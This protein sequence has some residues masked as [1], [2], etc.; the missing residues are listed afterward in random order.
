VVSALARGAGSRPVRNSSSDRSVDA[1]WAER[2]GRSE[3]GANRRVGEVGGEGADL[4]ASEW[5]REFRHETGEAEGGFPAAE[6]EGGEEMV[7]DRQGAAGGRIEQGGGG[8]GMKL[9]GPAGEEALE[10]AVVAVPLG[11]GGG[12]ERFAAELG[13]ELH[14]RRAGLRHA[15]EGVADRGAD[16]RMRDPRRGE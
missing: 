5:P 6:G 16:G 11:G 2:R 7:F 1:R 15:A 12:R 3:N 8:G 13:G 9:H 10:F 14:D 4:F